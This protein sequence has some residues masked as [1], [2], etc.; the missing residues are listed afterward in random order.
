M[1]P[2]PSLLPFDPSP[3][4]QLTD[5]VAH[6][7]KDDEFVSLLLADAGM[8][9]SVVAVHIRTRASQIFSEHAHGRFH[10]FGC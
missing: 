3:P 9:A 5:I 8:L 2:L 7:E 4:L 1:I 6:N 10:L